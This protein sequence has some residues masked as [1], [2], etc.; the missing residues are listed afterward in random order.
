MSKY[1]VI[2]DPNAGQ[3][4]PEITPYLHTFRVVVLLENSVA[5]LTSL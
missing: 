2:S 5:L 3:Y 1:G 4:G